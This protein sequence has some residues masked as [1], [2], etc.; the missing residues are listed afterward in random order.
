MLLKPAVAGLTVQRGEDGEPVLVAAPWKHI[1]ERDRWGQLRDKLTDP[2]RRTNQ[3]R[4]NEPRWLVSGFAACG[5]CGGPLRAGAAG[6]G[7]RL[8]RQ[9]V[10]PR[11]P[12]CRV[13]R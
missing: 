5:V 3:A 10:L 9:G 11:S 4:A 7:Q 12:E 2:A 8:H 1:I 13:G 6:T